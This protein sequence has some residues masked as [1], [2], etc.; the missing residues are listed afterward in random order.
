MKTF[1]EYLQGI[2]C[3]PSIKALLTGRDYEKE[4]KRGE[5]DHLT[6]NELAD[7]RNAIF[8]YIKDILQYNFGY[9]LE[10]KF[11]ESPD[12]NK[13]LEIYYTDEHRYMVTYHGKEF[14]IYYT[15]EHGYMV[16]YHGKTV[17]NQDEAFALPG[18][19]IT[20]ILN[21]AD[22]CR[23]RERKEQEAAEEGARLRLIELLSEPEQTSETVN[24]NVADN[25]D[26]LITAQQLGIIRNLARELGI[27]EEKECG[28]VFGET[29]AVD[30]LNREA[31]HFLIRRFQE[32]E[33]SDQRAEAAASA[34]EFLPSVFPLPVV[35]EN[36]QEFEIIPLV[37][38]LPLEMDNIVRAIFPLGFLAG[39]CLRDLIEGKTPKD[40]DVFCYEG[41]NFNQIVQSLR[42]IGYV[43]LFQ[44]PMLARLRKDVVAHDGTITETFFID[45]VTPRSNA[46]MQTFG[47]IRSVISKFDFTVCRIGLQVDALDPRPD[48]SRIIQDTDFN[49]DLEGKRLRIKNVVCPITSVKRVGKYALKGF[50]ISSVEILR[51]F[52]AWDDMETQE[53]EEL[54]ELLEIV[55]LPD[56]EL[57]AE[58]AERLGFLLYVD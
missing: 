35:T 11:T 31:A 26:D 28:A 33:A 14:E 9:L 6:L 47:D 15:D 5:I 34:E 43:E 56:G 41:T 48:N 29:V 12:N 45:V 36:V 38:A 55:E 24:P 52:K 2:V 49:A 32:I 22:L 1:E 46:R 25:L 16:T 30:M 7:L 8:G 53:K 3:A 13:E 21:A 42:Q 44:N 57:T 23:D 50:H 20:K 39:G 51:L 58:Q 19:W 4:F 10:R 18:S 40:Y 54:T 17:Y 27:D 37:S